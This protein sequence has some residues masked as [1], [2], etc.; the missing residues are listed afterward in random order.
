MPNGCVEAGSEY[1]ALISE[2]SQ[3]FLKIEGIDKVFRKEDLYSG[4]CLEQAPDM[5][6]LSETR[7]D[8]KGSLG[9]NYLFG[10]DRF[11]GMH[12]HNDA[13]LDIRGLNSSREKIY[14]IDLAPTILDFLGLS[15]PSHMDGVSLIQNSKSSDS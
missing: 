7:C 3:G 10:K 15:I 8:I 2:L 11:S 13:L 5:V 12:T 1:E 6:L 4:S 14:L 9:K